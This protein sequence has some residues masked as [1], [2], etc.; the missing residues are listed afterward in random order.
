MIAGRIPTAG[1]RSDLAA[2][3]KA[4]CPHLLFHDV[5]G[6]ETVTALLD[7]VAARQCDF[8]PAKVCRRQSDQRRFDLATRDCYRLKDLGV[9]M[10]PLRA[11]ID[12]IAPQAL[13]QLALFEP[14]V[15][16]K[17]FVI[18]AYGDGGYFALH[19]DTFEML[20]RV[21]I[22][23]CVYYFSA[24]PRR[25]RGGDLRLHGFPTLPAKSGL[26]PQTVDIMPETDSLVVFPSWLRHEVLPVEV[27]SR[28]WADGRF[29]I[30]CWIHRANPAADA[31]PATC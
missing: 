16:P 27:P 26:E 31:A 3:T 28:A 4:R 20:N 1:A 24:E 12:Q 17:E 30:T 2:A 22:L 8:T 13:Q 5:L 18:S 7:Y 9:F 10:A 25:F 14:A 11:R 6:T 21:R 19:I 15:E 29:T 23:T